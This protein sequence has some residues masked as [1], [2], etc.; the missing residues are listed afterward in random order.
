MAVLETGDFS[1]P[2]LPGDEAGPLKTANLLEGMATIGFDVVN[3]G[4]KD[5]AGGIA[6]F[7]SLA[8]KSKLALISGN[9][10]YRDTGEQ[11]FAPYVIREYELASGRRIR[12]G[13]LGLN[14]LNSAFAKDAGDGRI[15]MMRDPVEGVKL[16]LPAL[17][18]RVDLV[19][20]LGNLPLR[21]LTNVLEAAPG[22][23]LALISHG[24]RI[25]PGGNLETIAGRPVLYAGDQGKRLGEVRVVLGAKDE[26]PSFWA[27]QILLTQRY[28]AEP[29][30]Q[31]LIDRT[32]ARVNEIHRQRAEKAAASPGRPGSPVAPARTPAGPAPPA[33]E[34]RPFLT[35]NSCATCHGEAYDI[36]LQSGHA[37][38][39]DTLV[40]ANQD[41]NPE[42]VKCH[43]TG[44]EQPAGFVNARQTPDLANVQCEACH[45]NASE[46]V[47]DPSRPFGK[48]PPR[49]CFSCHTRE[50]SPEFVF[51]KYW[52]KIKH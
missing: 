12:L 26:P 14:A 3:V 9:F 29:K 44:W 49:A 24:P 10:I 22:I 7:R 45:G 47:L 39:F 15:V 36:Y 8:E 23:D 31:A 34:A 46:H 48:V 6:G 11:L 5:L 38:A 18:P 42:C 50:N 25:S 17:R 28:P 2:F 16:H 52:H 35:A 13:Y 4:E 19:V 40:K 37:H 21:D 41:F 43:V 33:P 30:L 51:F 32:I 1:A 27:N 20:L